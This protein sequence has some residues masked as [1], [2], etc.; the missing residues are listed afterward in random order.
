MKIIILLLF[1][2]IIM[3]VFAQESP[4]NDVSTQLETQIDQNNLNEM[5]ERISKL[6]DQ[7]FVENQFISSE[8]YTKLMNRLYKL[9]QD[10]EELGLQ[11]NSTNSLNNIIS[12]NNATNYYLVIGTFLAVGVTFL[13]IRLTTKSQK[14][15]NDI[16]Q[17][18]LNDKTIWKIL[19]ILSDEKLRDARREVYS[20]RRNYDGSV[21]TDNDT[22][23]KSCYYGPTTAEQNIGAIK[24]K[25]GLVGEIL[26]TDTHIAERIF[27]IYADTITLVWHAIEPE[28]KRYRI[29]N[30]DERHMIHFEWLNNQASEWYQNKGIS[31]PKFH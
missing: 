27:D 31:P 1:L 28:I 17:K 23:I 9:E 8:E 18:E 7:P 21:N 12:E 15:Q 16:L 30:E 11:I 26:K 5:E 3:P 10:S 13:G 19:E 20:Y 22:K 14:T 29:I 24:S 25:F 4:L 6:E 2:G